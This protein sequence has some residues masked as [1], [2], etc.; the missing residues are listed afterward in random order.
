MGRWD[1]TK[2]KKKYHLSFQ[3]VKRCEVVI[4]E[5][6][7][8]KS[9]GVCAGCTKVL[10]STVTL[11]G[12]EFRNGR[13]TVGS[14]G[15][16]PVLANEGK[17]QNKA[18]RFYWAFLE[19]IKSWNIPAACYFGLIG[20]VWSTPRSDR[21]QVGG[22]G[23]QVMRLCH[24]G[25]LG[26][27]AKDQGLTHSPAAFLG[28]GHFKAHVS[29]LFPTCSLQLFFYSFTEHPS[30]RRTKD[31]WFAMLLFLIECLFLYLEY[32]NI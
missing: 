10:A 16:D 12:D 9:N 3:K 11:A 28:P 8:W 20:E 6:R 18:K 23:P 31:L 2:K 29:P 27:K 19:S 7:W 4:L 17:P 21:A 1:E 14:L 26:C 13:R 30:L 15:P 5:Q 24:G 25:G 32:L 22:E